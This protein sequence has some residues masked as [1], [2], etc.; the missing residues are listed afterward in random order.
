MKVNKNIIIERGT[1][2][3]CDNHITG[4]WRLTFKN[5]KRKV[6]H[7]IITFDN[8]ISGSEKYHC[9]VDFGGCIGYKEYHTNNL[10]EATDWIHKKI[11]KYLKAP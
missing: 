1:R 5:L 7:E 6:F 9:Y 10:R 8:D 4:Y 3:F 2:S 11:K